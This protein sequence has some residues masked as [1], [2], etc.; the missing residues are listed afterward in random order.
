MALHFKILSKTS[1]GSSES[2][3][4]SRLCRASK[5]K[6]K[7][8]K[9][10][11]K[12]KKEEKVD[13]LGGIQH[14]VTYALASWSSIRFRFKKATQNSPHPSH[15]GFADDLRRFPIYLR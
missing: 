12:K 2:K 4:S 14:I 1:T 10:R 15:N 13:L 3:L 8:K 7:K 11:K 5:S 9:E 6:K